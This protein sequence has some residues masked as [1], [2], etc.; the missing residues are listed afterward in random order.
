MSAVEGVGHTPGPWLH[1]PNN[2]WQVSAG[3]HVVVASIEAGDELTGAGDG[4][5]W[6][7]ALA[8]ARLIAAAPDLLAALRLIVAENHGSRSTSVQR[9]VKHARAALAAAT[10]EG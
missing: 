9:M 10:G 1:D 5:G 8:N 3:E 4:P 6:Q 2:C 7:E